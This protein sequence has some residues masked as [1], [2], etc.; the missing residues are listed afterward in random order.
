MTFSSA[1]RCASSWNDW[2][3]K[4]SFSIRSLARPSSSSAKMSTPSRM[5][6]PSDGLSSPASSPSRVDLPEPEAPTIASVSAGCTVKSTL[7][8]MVSSPLAS[9]T[10]FDSWRTS[11]AAGG[12]A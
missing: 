5:T 1:F 7:C 11:I 12:L 6:V 4:P 10:R 2:N 3:T 8:R 9:A